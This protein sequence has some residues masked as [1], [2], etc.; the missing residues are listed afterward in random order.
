MRARSAGKSDIGKRRK[1]N[2]DAFLCH[3]ELG[4]FI[5][6][7]GMGGHAAGEVAAREAVEAVH[8]VI[9]R[10]KD[11]IERFREQPLT[12]ESARPICWLMEDAV[13]S[14]TFLVHDIAEQVP[15]FEGMGTTVSA[16]LLVGAYG[17]TAQVGDTRIYCLRDSELVQLTEDHTLINWQI[18]QGII[19]PDEANSHP[20]RNLITRAVGTREYVQVDLRLISVAVGDRFLLCSDGLYNYL[21]CSELHEILTFK[22]EDACKKLV[23]LANER[24]GKDNITAV[25]VEIRA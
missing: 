1:V 10:E 24:G 21:P 6:A 20:Y 9:M 12:R 4:F 13:Q 18:R 5:V 8:D 16:L 3:D 17:I 25:V 19:T 23:S 2:Q 22:P 15:R 14:A 11:A 7:D